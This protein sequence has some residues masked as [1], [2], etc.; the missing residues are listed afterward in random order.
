MF[1]RGDKGEVH[2]G[3]DGDEEPPKVFTFDKIFDENIEQD[4]LFEKTARA[5]V[6]NVLEGYNGTIFAYGQTGTGKTHTMEGLMTPKHLRGVMSRCFEAVY[7]SIEGHKDAQ[8]LIRASYLEIYKE[9]VRDLLSSNPKNKLLLHEKPDSG[10]YVKDLSSFICKNCEEMQAVQDTGRKNKLMGETSMNTRSS[11][12]HSVFTLTL[13]WSE[14]GPDGRT[15]LGSES[16]TWS[17]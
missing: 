14:L 11:R 8:F 9:N 3:R 13:E 16:W 17:I 1:E 7:D 2:V 6:G 12:S 5:I 15:I 10:V 4:V